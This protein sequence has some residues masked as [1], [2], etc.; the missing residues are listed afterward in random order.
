MFFE[1]ACQCSAMMQLEF[2]ESREE[3]AWLLLC[4][5]ASAHSACGFITPL[6]EELPEETKKFNIKTTPEKDV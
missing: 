2:N 1:V 3:A 6:L 4:R 5:F